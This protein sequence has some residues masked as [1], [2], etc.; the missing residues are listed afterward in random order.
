MYVLRNTKIVRECGVI[1]NGYVVID[2]GRIID[3]GRGSPPYPNIESEDL[4]GYTVLPGFIDTHIHG[5][6]GIDVTRDSEPEALLEIAY[7][8]VKYG[9]T[10]FTPTTISAPHDTLL[11][12]CKAI[13]NAK[14]MW[15][16]VHG[17]R[18]LGLHLEGPYINK[19]MAGAHNPRY[20]RRPSIQ[21]LRELVEASNNSVIQVTVAPEVENSLD[22]IRY[23]KQIG[24]VVSAGHTNASYEEG[25]KAIESGVTK[26]TH[27]FNGMK[28]FHHRDPGIALALIENPSVYLEI[29]ADYVH[30]H[31][32]VVRHVVKYAGTD[33]VVLITDAIAATG[34]SDGEYSLGDLRIRVEQGVTKLFDRNV[35]AGSMLTMDKAFRNLLDLGFNIVDVAR[36]SSTTPAKSLDLE[37]KLKVGKIEIGYL[38]DIVAIDE[39]YRVR[40]VYIEGEK[41]LDR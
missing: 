7:R 23:V 25:V 24:I 10:S 8:L 35:L 30:L 1:D 36:M 37:S 26:A 13:H 39:N 38:A 31:P 2:R 20:I 22:F 29:I 27:L 12:V 33:R 17:A 34:L 21:E 9:V 3:I 32:A 41:V 5:I 14:A 19:E 18:I 28:K 11:A 15:R 6:E 40:K 4:D 16:P